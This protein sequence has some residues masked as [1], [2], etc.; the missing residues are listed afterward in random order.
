MHDIR[1][2]TTELRKHRDEARSPTIGAADEKAVGL[3][4][5]LPLSESTDLR[6][7]AAVGAA[8]TI[9]VVIVLGWGWYSVAAFR[10]QQFGFSPAI[11]GVAA[12]FVLPAAVLP[13]VGL[14]W[15]AVALGAAAALLA[16]VLAAEM[17]AAVEEAKFRQ[18]TRT[19]PP[20]A[21]V[22]VQMRQRPFAHHTLYYDPRSGQWGAG[23]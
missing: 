15:R 19:L 18:E 5:E 9:G 2:R 20:D 10:T 8:R 3:L 23:D 13:F 17:F 14:R 1:F 4:Q 11:L 7:A 16:A 6:H 21:A 22:V 12:V